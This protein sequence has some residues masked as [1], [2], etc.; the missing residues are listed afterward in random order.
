M[1]SKNSPKPALD[2]RLEQATLE[3]LRAHPDI[4]VRHPEVVESLT[5]PHA[6]GKA[7]SLVQYQVGVL[8]DKNRDLRRRMHELVANVRDNEDLSRRLHHMTMGLVECAAVDELFTRIYQ[9]LLD[10]FQAELTAIRVFAAPRSGADRGLAEFAVRDGDHRDL[11][12]PFLAQGKPVCGR[13]RRDQLHYLLGERGGEVGS[14]SLIP[15]GDGRPFGV[16]AVCSRDTQRYHPGM[17]TVFL[18][19]LGEIVSHVLVPYVE[20]RGLPR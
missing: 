10:Q 11:F 7:V 3:Y 20:E 12:G 4:F 14:G 19:Q 15:L 2:P 5:I 6:C 17:G 8:R 13:L 18:R 1:T 9:A 16:L